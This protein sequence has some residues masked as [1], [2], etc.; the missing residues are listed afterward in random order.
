VSFGLVA[1]ACLEA[2]LT[3]K[4]IAK[5]NVEALPP[6]RRWPAGLNSRWTSYRSPK[7]LTGIMAVQSVE[8]GRLVELLE[9]CLGH[10]ICSLRW[11]EATGSESAM[12]EH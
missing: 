5:R 9:A 7:G 3:D 10:Q 1:G 6:L 4:P 12:N 11:E 8:N 2:I